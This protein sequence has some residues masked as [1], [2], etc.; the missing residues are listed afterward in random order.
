MLRKFF[1]TVA[2]RPKMAT[3]V[4]L[5]VVAIIEVI[6][7]PDKFLICF[8]VTLVLF[9][10]VILF[11]KLLV[12]FLNLHFSVKKYFISKPIR[13]VS[14]VV[15]NYNYAKYLKE[16]VESIVSQTYPISELIILD[17]ASSDGSVKAIK[18]IMADL[19][20]R[21][22]NLKVRFIPNQKNSGN[23]FKQ[24]EKGFSESEGDFVW[25]CEAD[26]TCSKYFLNTVMRSFNDDKVV[27]SYAESRAID[28]N[29]R[30]LMPDLRTWVDEFKTRHWDKSYVNDGKKELANFL[31]VNN[32]IPN[33]SGVVFR[34]INSPIGKYLR[35]AQ[36]FRLVGDWY[37]YAKYLLNGKIAYHSEALNYRR[38]QDSSFT[39]TTDKYQQF[40]EI[41]AVQKNIGND[42]KLSLD[43]K[44]KIKEYR[45]VVMASFGLSEKELD[46]MAIPFEK[47][48]KKSKV[49]D[50]I[51]LSVIVSAYNAEEYIDACLESVEAAL[52]EKSEILVVNDGSTDRT[53]EIIKEHKKKCPSI[54]YY[55]KKN[56][57]LSSVKN[58]G[59]SRARGRYVIFMDADDKIKSDG[60][61]VMLKMALENDAD[62][63][64]CDMALIYDDGRVYNFPVY[65]EKPGG[66]L[67]F[68]VDGLMASSNNK[69][70][71]KVL[72]DKVGKY[73]E[74]KNNE[75]VAI[76]PVLMAL[77]K[78][79]QYIPSSFYEYYQREGS[80]QNSEFDEKRLMIFDTV[81]QA[82]LAIQ[83][84]LPKEAESIFGIMVGNQLIALLV[85]VMCNIEDINKRNKFI[86]EF[87]EKYRALNISDNIYIKKYCDELGLFELP[88]YILTAS[89]KK[90]YKYIKGDNKLVN[91]LDY[92][93]RAFGIKM[94]A[95]KRSTK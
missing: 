43:A 10:A 29:G 79:T 56:E 67:G 17:D 52:P 86:G 15:P 66:L 53:L 34:K 70:V 74:G 54:N 63:V 32:T 14:A 71:K 44:R 6:L 51:L 48:L 59:L 49:N 64:V 73:P 1:Y 58:F 28:E 2:N 78:D 16:R 21:Y 57:G 95:K 80:I 47:I 76:T 39:S 88:R 72:Y 26:D 9:A 20:I 82:Y 23:V 25:I 27:L 24:W 62:V 38:M 7:F 68:L 19:K 87:C 5:F 36:K 35:E 90:I 8:G 84:I 61:L 85:H 22:P 91:F 69:M 42:V 18:D 33:A 4:V 93:G 65:H 89:P 3:L 37:F 83:K 75:D 81:E 77:S 11:Y 46:Y 13:K 40:L 55:T 94:L 41:E 92:I 31:C 60:Y 45:R 50:K 30:E 12:W